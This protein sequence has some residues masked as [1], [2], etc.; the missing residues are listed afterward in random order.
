MTNNY[1]NGYTTEKFDMLEAEKRRRQFYKEEQE[2]LF[3]KVEIP[4]MFVGLKKSNKRCKAA[5]GDRAFKAS[6]FVRRNIDNNSWIFRRP[7]F[8]NEEV[9]IKL[10]WITNYDQVD[11]WI[12]Q[13]IENK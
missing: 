13:N 6:H 7:E 2:R 9:E 1:Y 12:R 8:E 3:G 5:L 4:D 10:C 11:A